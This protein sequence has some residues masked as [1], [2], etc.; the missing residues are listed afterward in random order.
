MAKKLHLAVSGRKWA[1]IAH[2]KRHLLANRI[3]V[4]GSFSKFTYYAGPSVKLPE[5]VAVTFQLFFI[6]GGQ[7]LENNNENLQFVDNIG[8]VQT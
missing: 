1:R 6:T 5:I 8:D 2:L 4:S 3:K 7:K